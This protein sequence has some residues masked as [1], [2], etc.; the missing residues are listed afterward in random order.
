MWCEEILGLENFGQPYEWEMD[1]RAI[2]IIKILNIYF[3][4]IQAQR[5]QN[6]KAIIFISRL[7]EWTF[8]LANQA[9]QTGVIIWISQIPLSIQK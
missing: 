2:K 4:E 6:R 9:T 7:V 8:F 3:E 1:S 5:S